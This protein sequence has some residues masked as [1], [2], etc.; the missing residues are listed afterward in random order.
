M[1][2]H[3]EYD[4]NLVDNTGA[5]AAYNMDYDESLTGTGFDIKAG[6]IFRP[7]ENSPFRIGLSVSTPI[8]YDLTQNAYLK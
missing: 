7:L 2:N 5:T 6:V 3:L 4:E 1:R 8:F